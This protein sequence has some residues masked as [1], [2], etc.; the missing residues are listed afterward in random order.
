MAGGL[1]EGKFMIT[2]G[3]LASVCLGAASVVYFIWR[4]RKIG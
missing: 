4:D 3:L 1:S 2:I